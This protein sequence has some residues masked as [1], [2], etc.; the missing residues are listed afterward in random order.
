M[1]DNDNGSILDKEISL[2]TYIAHYTRVDIDKNLLVFFLPG[3]NFILRPT[4][5]RR[6]L[7]EFVASRVHETNKPYDIAPTS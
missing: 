3:C 6:S 4:L 1:I 7:L 5:S 2:D